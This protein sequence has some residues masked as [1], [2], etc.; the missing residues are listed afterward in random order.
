MYFT[1][2]VKNVCNYNATRWQN[3]IE[4]REKIEKE[5]PGIDNEFLDRKLDEF[6]TCINF[7]KTVP[8][9]R[10]L[11]FIKEEVKYGFYIEKKYEKGRFIDTK[12]LLSE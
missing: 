7:N 1:I 3:I 10:G 4:L 11:H 12:I 8:Y 9:P 5:L 6:R 2:F